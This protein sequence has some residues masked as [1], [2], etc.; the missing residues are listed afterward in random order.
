MFV[1]ERSVFLE[2]CNLGYVFDI[3]YSCDGFLGIFF[4]G[5]VYEVE[6]MVVISVVIFDDDLDVFKVSLDG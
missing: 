3:V 5:V 2:G 6:V 4:L 1:D